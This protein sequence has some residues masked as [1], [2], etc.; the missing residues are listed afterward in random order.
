MKLTNK[1]SLPQPIVD[2]VSNDSY[3]K[4]DANISVTGLLRP[5]RIAALEKTHW[6]SLEE[7]VSDRMWSL[8]GQVVHG[9]LERAESTGIA[10]RRLSVKVGDWTVSG[11]MDRY[12]KGTLQDYKFVSVYKIKSGVPLEYEQQMNLYA[13][14]LRANGHFVGKLELIAII[15]DWSKLEAKRD[16]SYPQAQVVNMDVPLWTPLKAEEFLKERVKLHQDA[17]KTLPLCSQEDRWAKSS[18]YAVM[19]SGRKSAVRLYDTRTEA[20]RHAATDGTLT[21]VVRP[22]AN[23]RCESY[24]SVAKFCTQFQSLSSSGEEIA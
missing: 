6:N 7:D 3:T 18:V 23:T 12:E 16:P 1:L 4:G 11:Q 21:V 19:K 10:E 17:L 15:R 13:H 2:A 8:L 24:C 20:E 22:G 14:L 5:P 9:I